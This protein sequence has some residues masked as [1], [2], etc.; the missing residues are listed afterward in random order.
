MSV[1]WC[2]HSCFTCFVHHRRLLRFTAI[3]AYFSLLMDPR[4]IGSFRAPLHAA[5]WQTWLI[6]SGG[7]PSPSAVVGNIIVKAHS[8]ST[9]SANELQWRPRITKARLLKQS[10]T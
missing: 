7:I 3:E 4:L 9:G 5:N 10:G 1:R 2:T 8:Q 6:V